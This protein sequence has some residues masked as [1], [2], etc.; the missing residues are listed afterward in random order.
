[1]NITKYFFR[2]VI[3]LLCVLFFAFFA[4]AT[5]SVATKSLI[6]LL[7]AGFGFILA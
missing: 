7:E 2:S 6:I 1:M 3:S 5:F 4:F